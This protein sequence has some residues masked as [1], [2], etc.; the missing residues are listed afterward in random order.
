MSGLRCCDD[1]CFDVDGMRDEYCFDESKPNRYASERIGA[2]RGKRDLAAKYGLPFGS[3][4]NAEQIRAFLEDE[5]EAMDF[6]ER[7]QTLDWGDA[8]NAG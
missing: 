7:F 2:M 4:A 8:E 6:V 5:K 3:Q 1:S